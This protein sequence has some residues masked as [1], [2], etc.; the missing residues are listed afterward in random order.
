MASAQKTV[1]FLLD[2]IAKAGS[3]AARKMFGEYGL[4]CDGKMVALVCDDQLF[5]K[6][7]AAGRSYLGT[8]TEAAPYNGARPCFLIPGETWDDSARLTELVRLTA[9]ALPVPGRKRKADAQ[10]H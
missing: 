7:T 3:V 8:V 6:P 9:A 1:D 10:D 5:L 2:Q 4:Y